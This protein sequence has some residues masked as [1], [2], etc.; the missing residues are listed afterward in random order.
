MSRRAGPITRGLDRL[1]AVLRAL[2]SA[3]V[4]LGGGLLILLSAG[5]GLEVLMRRFAGHSF[6]GLDEL[7]GYTL[8][9]VGAIALT[10]ALLARGHIRIDLVHARLGRWGQAV[11]DLVA[12]A[13][14]IAFF[15]LLLNFAWALLDRSLTMGTR[16]MT[17]LAVLLWI[18]Q[19]LWFAALALFGLTAVTLFLRV[20]AAL[21]GGDLATARGLIGARSADDELAEEIALNA[22]AAGGQSL[23]TLEM[24]P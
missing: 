2:S 5:V 11:L 3:G 18:P 21:L 20:V 13:G 9:I 22:E 14:L 12:L 17:P 4:W 19:S 8:A 1:L 10:E 15:A 7:G 23:Q 24:R 6:A 16:S